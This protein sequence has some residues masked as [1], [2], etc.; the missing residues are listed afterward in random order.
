MKART[1]RHPALSKTALQSLTHS[2]GLS[3][4][5]M[6]EIFKK[7]EETHYQTLLHH[8]LVKNTFSHQV[9]LFLLA[10]ELGALAPLNTLLSEANEKDKASLLT[11]CDDQG[12]TALHLSIHA[13]HDECA[14][15]LLKTKEARQLINAPNKARHT[16]L[17]LAAKYA[18]L[19]LFQDMLNHGG[20]ITCPTFRNKHGLHTLF[21]AARHSQTES[22]KKQALLTTQ[23]NKE[24]ANAIQKNEINYFNELLEL[25]ALSSEALSSLQRLILNN[26]V[27]TN[28]LNDHQLMN[29]MRMGN[30]REIDQLICAHYAQQ[31]ETLERAKTIR[32][33]SLLESSMPII[34]RTYLAGSIFLFEQA[35]Q[36]ALAKKS[37]PFTPSTDSP[38]TVK[39]ALHHLHTQSLALIK[40]NFIPEGRLL[41]GVAILI[42][43]K[44]EAW[45]KRT[46]TTSEEL[47]RR[48][49]FI[50]KNPAINSCFSQE[51]RTSFVT[52][53]PLEPLP[54]SGPNIASPLPPDPALLPPSIPSGP[55]FRI[56]R[57]IAN[58][59]LLLL[60]GILLPLIIYAASRRSPNLKLL[61]TGQH[62]FLPTQ[63]E[64][65]LQMLQ[66][67]LNQPLE[68]PPH[69]LSPS[70]SS[71][72]T[73]SPRTPRSP[74]PSPS[75]RHRHSLA[76]TL[77]PMAS[78]AP[79]DDVLQ[80][81]NTP[82]IDLT[83][84]MRATAEEN[85]DADEHIRSRTASSVS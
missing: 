73:S 5:E 66:S 49:D 3:L 37:P 80:R 34:S 40:R 27:F 24:I 48:C 78:L 41:M 2:L 76:A 13:R 58:Y 47:K 28:I 52:A 56:W 15:T 9:A 25:N 31:S 75:P 23:L 82:A 64:R 33:K 77:E 83:A 19:P 51:R 20:K 42:N 7:E 10:A 85:L 61:L 22:E 1:S 46:I 43:E 14:S 57:T 4:D 12:N 44:L 26:T 29:A 35:L 53:Q 84:S 11:A 60:G 55:S 79:T 6:K 59:L 54:S 67:A 8:P 36:K 72:H 16:P 68:R 81:T 63:S 45:G 39:T 32:A 70:L 18:S 30:I 74:S 17:Y 21:T 38:D 50:L 71:L 69:I 62:S 65:A